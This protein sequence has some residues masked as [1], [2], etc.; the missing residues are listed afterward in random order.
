[1]T[2]LVKDLLGSTSN[3]VHSDAVHLHVKRC[4]SRY[5]LPGSFQLSSDSEVFAVVHGHFFLHPVPGVDA[6]DFHAGMVHQ[7][8]EELRGD[9]EV[10]AGDVMY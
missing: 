8:I 3:A 4:H 5:Q 6:M 2:V 9:Q 7:I 10:S 1:M